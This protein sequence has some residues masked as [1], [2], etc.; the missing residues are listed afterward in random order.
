PAEPPEQPHGGG[1]LL[2]LPCSRPVRR[3]V[4]L[5]SVI[6]AGFPADLKPVCRLVTQRE[7]TFLQGL[8]YSAEVASPVGDI[9]DSPR[10][11]PSR[12]G[13]VFHIGGH[14]SEAR[15]RGR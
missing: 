10:E 3:K 8:G 9:L 4:R 6:A 2:L 5:I 11:I 15:R 1:S 14:T 12:V 13:L 7:R